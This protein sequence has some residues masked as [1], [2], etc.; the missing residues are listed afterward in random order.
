MIHW[1]K[2]YPEYLLAV[3]KELS[4]DPNYNQLFLRRNN[5]LISHG[6]I[7][8]R[9][10]SIHRFPFLIAFTNATPFALPSFYPLKRILTEKEVD[11]ISHLPQEQVFGSI[12][13]KIVFHY[14]LRHQNSSGV[15]CIMEWD[16]LDDG[17][18]FYGLKT[19]LK[20]VK[21]WCTGTITGDFPPDSEEVEYSAHFT[22]VDEQLHFFYPESFLLADLVEGEGY[23]DLYNSIPKILYLNSDHYNY[24]G[25]LLIGRNN[26]G[27]FKESEY[28]FPYSLTEIGV[29]NQLDLID[30]KGLINNLIEE[31]K[32]LR[33]YW[34]SVDNEPAPFE[35]FEDLVRIIGNGDIENGKKR[36]VPL[37]L[38]EIKS[39]PDYFFMA[40]RFPNRKARQEFQLFRIGKSEKGRGGLINATEDEI[41]DFLFADYQDVYAVRSALLSDESFHLRNSGRT[42]RNQLK[43][44]AVNMMGIGALGSEIG[45]CLGK[46]G[47][48]E[49]WLF[50]NQI[51]KFENSVRH[52][53]GVEW[54]GVPKIIAVKRLIELHNPF[55]NVFAFPRDINSLELTDLLENSILVSTIADDNTEA[56]LNERALS[57]NKTTYYIRALRGGKVARIFR[58]IPGKD[59]C[60]HCLQLYRNG[61]SELISIPPDPDLP[62]LR[63]ECNNPIRPASAADLKLISS[64]AARI[65]LDE[66]QKGPQIDNHWLWSTE[67]I[68]MLQPY[69]LHRQ[70]IVPH[71]NCHYCKQDEKSSMTIDEKIVQFMQWLVA[72]NPRIETGGVLAGCIDEN[73]NVHIEDASGPGPKAICTATRF[74]KDVVYCQQYLDHLS[75]ESNGHKIYIGEWHSHPSRDNRPSNTDI[76]SLSEI[77]NQ[78]EYLTDS[79]VMII[80]S[81]TGKPSCTIHPAGKLYYFTKLSIKIK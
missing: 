40:L 37:C 35:N 46:A 26:A 70:S 15:L 61:D 31:K 68:S 78:K 69:Q 13:D 76:K 54:V 16:N 30:K 18:K 41:F 22:K 55:I 9:L 12:R 19:I 7:V 4:N 60:F 5:L 77:A 50:D 74:E 25:S 33:M 14:H 62:T 67:E 75:N 21:D 49:L 58:V 47:V 39:K 81:N 72:A 51:M 57:L 42:D 38:E 56:F 2:K 52:L 27:L 79:P 17:I 66:F 48:G 80:F 36:L 10:N 32:V 73:K 53:A 29:K 65:I 28:E 59:A 43:G 6:N 11:T 3:T 44:K 34:F 23:A 63:S 1:F 24:L 64:L 20:R 45:D 71:P 8:V